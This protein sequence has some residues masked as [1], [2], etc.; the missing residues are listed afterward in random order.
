MEETRW[1]RYKEPITRATRKYLDSKK[2]VT[3]VM[4]PETY[5]EIKAYCDETG[6][7]LQALF[8]DA[9]LEKVRRG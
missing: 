6:I 5:E 9:A 2:K 8:R 3:V 1:E 7:S 4:P